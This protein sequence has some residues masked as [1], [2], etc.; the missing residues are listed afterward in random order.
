VF[1][2]GLNDSLLSVVKV[3]VQYN[4]N[5]HVLAGGLNDS[6]LPVVKVVV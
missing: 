1:A 6:L 3:I 4:D 5:V 2:G